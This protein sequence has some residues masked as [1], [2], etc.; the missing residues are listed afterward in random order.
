[1]R[2]DRLSTWFIASFDEVPLAVTQTWL[3]LS[4][5]VAA[6]SAV[7]V[8][9]Q[10]LSGEY[11]VSDDGRQHLFWMRRFL[12]PGLFPEDA[13]ADYFESLA[14]AGYTA[15][16]H[17]FAELG[18]DPLDVARVLPLPLAVVTAFFAFWL[19]LEFLPVPFAGFLASTLYLQNLWMRD[20][21]ASATAR[22]FLS[23]LLLAF[24]YAVAGRRWGLML[25]TM[26]GLGGFYPTYVLVASGVLLLLPWGDS[27]RRTWGF[28]L[29]GLLVAA[30]VLLPYAMS[31]GETLTLAAARQLPE[32]QPG[33]RTAYFAADWGR[34]WLSGSRTGLQPALDPPL[35]AVGVL[36]PAVWRWNPGKSRKLGLLL[37]LIGVS[38]GLFLAAHA[39]AFRLH[40]PSRYT[41]HSLRVVM[42]V[43]AAVTLVLLLEKWRWLR[44][45]GVLGI[46]LGLL[47]YP[48]TLGNY[49][50]TNLIVGGHPPIYEFFAE[51]PLETR[52]ASLASAANHLPTFARRSLYVGYE[53][54]LPF[55][56]AYYE[57]MR[58]RSQALITAHYTPDLAELRQF[59]ET[60]K[61]D[62]LVVEDGAFS[63]D[64]LTVSRW[65][66]SHPQLAAVVRQSLERGE[67]PALARLVEP[68]TVLRHQSLA[69]VAKSCIV[70]T[71]FSS[72]PHRERMRYGISKIFLSLAPTGDRSRLAVGDLLS[73]F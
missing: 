48:L 38:L 52:I 46:L 51:Q 6:V 70:K 4:L 2:R 35:L 45:W 49:P 16:Y 47:L 60:E 55:H 20:D 11:V 65:E 14:P 15:F 27:R 53:Y 26:A 68:C 36:L 28:S 13:I 32:L 44:R 41:Q 58:G 30:V 43:A 10:T 8:L 31:S 33:G 69:V 7:P 67:V 19:T 42:A 54:V 9:S 66:R 39:L 56:R 1:M 40:L 71:E 34:F 3:L 59:L 50:R 12:E 73:L 72:A 22:A 57:L 29:T 24:L 17:F 37:R 64:Y 63:P 5:A 21:L 18:F 25:L 23:P 61:I 62:F